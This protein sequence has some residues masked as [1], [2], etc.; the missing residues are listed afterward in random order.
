M[1][2]GLTAFLAVGLLSACIFRSPLEKT[3]ANLGDIR[4]GN[5]ELRL[6]AST[7][8]G[9][10]TGFE[11][12]GPFSMPEG[13]QLPQA[14][15]TYTRYAG[16][17]EDTFGF[18]S[19]GDAAFLRMGERF[20]ALPEENVRS[21]RGSDDPGNRGPFSGLNLDGWIPDSEVVATPENS[22]VETI[23]GDLDVVAA[24]N[25]MLGIAREYAGVDRPEI[26]GDDADRLRDAVE[27]A[28]L[29]LVTGKDDR[30]LRSLL[31][32]MDLG[33]DPPEAFRRALEGFTGV[34]FTLELKLTE[35]NSDVSVTAPANP[36]PYESLSR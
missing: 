11:L 4:S 30:I 14:D 21:M 35:P 3:A 28:E 5:M 17:T 8:E 16:T 23:T 18:I 12:K 9:Q 7:P 32:T 1:A 36:L 33:R 13:E 31:V 24:V 15:L 20:Y 29:T 10:R 34:N 19:T 2:A 25:D 27:K 26:E 22:D 6:I